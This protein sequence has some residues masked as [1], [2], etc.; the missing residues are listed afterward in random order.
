MK[1][2]ARLIRASDRACYCA[3]LLSISKTLLFHRFLL[4]LRICN[5]LL[6]QGFPC[7]IGSNRAAGSKI[8]RTVVTKRHLPLFSRVVSE[9]RSTS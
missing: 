6:T 7:F 3:L 9:N 8:V 1:I 2:C 4:F 5:V